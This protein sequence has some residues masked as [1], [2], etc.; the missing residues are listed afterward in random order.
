[1]T[2]RDPRTATPQDQDRPPRWELATDK[3]GNLVA[4]L[5]GTHPPLTVTAPDLTTLRKQ[6]KAVI[7]RAML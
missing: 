6:I 3:D 5:T 4:T 1:M 2:T 7:M